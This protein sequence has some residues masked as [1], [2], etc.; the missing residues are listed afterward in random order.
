MSPRRAAGLRAAPPAP[1]EKWLPYR[2]ALIAGRLG[3]FVTPMFRKR[4]DLPL[5]AVRTLAVIARYQPLSAAELGRHTSADAFKVARAIDL[6]LRRKL[7]RRDADPADRR[8]AR[9]ELTAKGQGIYL[10]YEKFARRVEHLWLSELSK[11][12]LEVL[13]TV[14]DKV[15]S[16]VATLDSRDAWKAFVD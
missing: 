12:E 10:D 2:F 6:L 13:Y 16:K 14:L 9:L 3:A 7:I 5:Q 1:L 15:D 4:Y 11:A 8:R